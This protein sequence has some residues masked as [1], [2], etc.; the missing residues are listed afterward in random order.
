MEHI[1]IFFSLS[2]VFAVIFRAPRGLEIMKSELT[3]HIKKNTEIYRCNTKKDITNLY[4]LFYMKWKLKFFNVLSCIVHD[5]IIT[6]IRNPRVVVESNALEQF[7]CQVGVE[8]I[9]PRQQSATMDLILYK[10]FTR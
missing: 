9:K 1:K 10:N 5:T 4:L 3:V 6:L 8:P 7:F 2:I